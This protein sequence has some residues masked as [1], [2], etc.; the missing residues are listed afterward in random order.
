MIYITRN[1][2]DVVV[3][4]YHFARLATQ[5]GFTGKFDNF[6]EMF[7]EGN[8][9]FKCNNPFNLIQ[10]KPFFIFSSAIRTMVESFERLY[11]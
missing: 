9:N 2:K 3:S 6:L 8:G 1:P 4:Y 5:S 7:L 10:N 11:S